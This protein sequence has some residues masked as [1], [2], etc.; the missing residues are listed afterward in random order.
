MPATATTLYKDARRA[1]RAACPRSILNWREARY[2]ARHGEIEM[3]LVEFLCCSDRDA[4]DIG[5]NHGGY[6]HFLR[7]HARRV[8][9]FEPMADFVEL[10]RQKFPH[11]VAIEQ[12]ALSDRAGT[13]ELYMPVVGGTALAGCST[14]SDRAWASYG[15]RRSFEVPVNLLD[16]VYRGDVGFIKIDIE[17]HEEAA[18]NGAVETIGRCQPRMLVEV[19]DCLSPGGVQRVATFF[20]ARGY[21]GYYVH[22]RQLHPI[23]RF[24]VDELQNPANQPD[25][26]ASLHDRPPLSHYIYNFIFLPPGE[27]EGTLSAMARRLAS[28]EA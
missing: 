8:L 2:F 20:A 24:S 15:D 13:A 25:M 17:G 5:A 6:I 27:P 3:H 9:A 23:E 28:L 18:L 26:T 4:I 21:R 14:L 10:L 11:G 22:D 7:R 12:I 16:N 19:E 1:L